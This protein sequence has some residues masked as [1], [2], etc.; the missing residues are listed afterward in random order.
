ML[1]EKL[2]D[3]GEEMLTVLALSGKLQTAVILTALAPAGIMVLGAI[4][5]SSTPLSNP[6]LAGIHTAVA[7]VVPI[8]ALA[9]FARCAVLAVSVV[10]VI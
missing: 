1:I 7:G 9:G 8:F 3:I 5:L 6:L 10:S 4:L 2:K